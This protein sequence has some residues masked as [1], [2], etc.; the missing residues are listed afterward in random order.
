VLI[1]AITVLEIAITV[2]II[3]LTVLIIAME[4]QWIGQTC[5]ETG[6]TL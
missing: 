3:A 2:R 6:G 1:I 5:A 4:G